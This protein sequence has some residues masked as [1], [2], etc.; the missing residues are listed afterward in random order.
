MDSSSSIGNNIFCAIYSTALVVGPI[1]FAIGVNQS[2]KA[3]E[4]AGT[5][6]LVDAVEGGS[7]E[8]EL[9]DSSLI[10]EEKNESSQAE[11]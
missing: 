3:S 1:V 4:R 6:F 9:K 5:I 7:R 10:E 2:W 8:E 11:K